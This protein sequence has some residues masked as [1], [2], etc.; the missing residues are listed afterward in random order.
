MEVI[1]HMQPNGVPTPMQYVVPHGGSVDIRP[2]AGE[3]W[4][5]VG[6]LADGTGTGAINLTDG[7]HTIEAETPI[8]FL[9][10]TAIFWPINHQ[11]YL[12]I[13]NSGGSD[14]NFYISAIVF[15]DAAIQTVRTL[16]GNINFSG[17]LVGIG[18]SL[19]QNDVVIMRPPQGQV[20]Q[21]SVFGTADNA[22]FPDFIITD[23]TTDTLLAA[24]GS[25]G[26]TAFS[27]AQTAIISNQYY[28]KFHNPN[29]AA[30]IIICCGLRVQ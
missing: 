27:P 7:T 14:F 23:G 6:V 13:S 20:W 8:T 22:A 16:A 1:R 17:P 3:T 19:A 24:A 15:Q 4:I 29:A 9:N 30:A 18:A 25:P 10:F 12:N 28:L 2:P 21:V 5:I 26:G 11:F